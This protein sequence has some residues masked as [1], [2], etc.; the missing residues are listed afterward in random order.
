LE[1][2]SVF[3]HSELEFWVL[4][5]LPVEGVAVLAPKLKPV[6]FVLLS[7]VVLAPK[8]KPD[9]ELGAG[10]EAVEGVE[11][12]NLNPELVTVPA[13]AGFFSSAFLGL[14]PG[15][16]SAQQAHSSFSASFCIIHTGQLHLFDL[17]MTIGLLIGRGAAAA[18]AAATSG[19]D[20]SSGLVEFSLV[21]NRSDKGFSEV[22]ETSILSELLEL[23]D[24]V[25]LFS[26]VF[27]KEN[28]ADFE[29]F[30]DEPK[31]KSPLSPEVFAES[32][33]DPF[34]KEN[35]AEVVSFLA[36]APDPNANKDEGCDGGDVKLNEAAESPEVPLV[37]GFFKKSKAPPDELPDAASTPAEGAAALPKPPKPAKVLGPP[38]FLVPRRF[39][40]LITLPSIASLLA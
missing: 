34:P 5:L 7:E 29:A 8:T 33:E 10:A 28:V 20:A 1:Y 30:P 38:S 21:L 19:L 17:G 18:G 32:V 12:P 36:L 27:P 14:H 23:S 25:S 35:V 15:L 16:G 9:P 40:F 4:E 39:A 37:P 6:E 11:E 2:S 24:V 26:G 31:A 22:A 3:L 13:N